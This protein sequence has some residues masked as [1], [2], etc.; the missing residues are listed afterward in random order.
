[1]YASNAGSLA[2]VGS[3][4]LDGLNRC[5]LDDDGDTIAATDDDDQ[6]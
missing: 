5:K 1:M 4:Y 2:E 3:M 6:R